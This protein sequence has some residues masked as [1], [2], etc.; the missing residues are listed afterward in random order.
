MFI[1]PT[2]C[3]SDKNTSLR[4]SAKPSTAADGRSTVARAWCES[5][6]ANSGLW[7][8]DKSASKH[9]RC[10][11]STR[12]R[13][14]C[15]LT[16]PLRQVRGKLP[17]Q[18]ESRKADQRRLYPLLSKDKGCS[19]FKLLSPCTVGVN[20]SWVHVTLLLK[21]VFKKAGVLQVDW[22]CNC[23]LVVSQTTRLD[24]KCWF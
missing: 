9:F 20:K 7:P 4:V 10:P 1:R 21:R 13:G 6:R 14:P 23:L 2:W 17:A 11:A 3:L 12:L 15:K 8:P 19:Y 22:T 18:F 24:L 5:S 16:T